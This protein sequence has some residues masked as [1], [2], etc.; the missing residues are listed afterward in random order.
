MPDKRQ[1]RKAAEACRKRVSP[2]IRRRGRVRRIPARDDRAV[3]QGAQFRR[4]CTE[5]MRRF[6]APRRCAPDFHF[7]SRTPFGPERTTAPRGGFVS[8]L[9]LSRPGNPPGA[10]TALRFSHRVSVRG[11]AAIV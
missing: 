6:E 8:V 3:A 11:G 10:A 4:A 9:R 5:P 2:P 7:L 1:P